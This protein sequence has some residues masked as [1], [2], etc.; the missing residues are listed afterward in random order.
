MSATSTPLSVDGVSRALAAYATGPEAASLSAPVV[1]ALA[2][3][4][5]DSIGCA[6]GGFNE[7]P[8]M[9]ARRLVETVLSR[10]GSDELFHLLR[11]IAEVDDV[12]QLTEILRRVG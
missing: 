3:H 10:E 6:L 4:L 2:W 7:R 1:D 8:C 5:T 9:V 12:N 11:G